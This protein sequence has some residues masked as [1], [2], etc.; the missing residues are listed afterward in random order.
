[1]F[2]YT[3]IFLEHVIDHFEGFKLYWEIFMM[4]FFCNALLAKSQVCFFLILIYA[5]LNFKKRCVVHDT[6]L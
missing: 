1:M 4:G 3:V 2:K 6:L 5:Q